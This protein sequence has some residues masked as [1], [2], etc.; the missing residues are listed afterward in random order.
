MGFEAGVSA[1]LVELKGAIEGVIE[2]L[3]GERPVSASELAARLGVSRAMGWRVWKLAG[4]E[5]VE[6]VAGRLPG[7]RA[8]GRFCD[9]ARA[10]GVGPALVDRAGRA[11]ARFR[12]LLAEQSWDSASANALLSRVGGGVDPGVEMR[13]RRELFRAQ[14]YTMGV[15]CLTQYNGFVAVPGPDVLRVELCFLTAYAGL[16]RSRGDQR[17]LINRR[18]VTN[19][20]GDT[21]YVRDGGLRYEALEATGGEFER[22]P[23]LIR[24]LCSDPTAP[25]RRRR[26]KDSLEDEL[27]P[28]EVGKTAATDVYFG[29]RLLGL[30]PDE[31]PTVVFYPRVRVPAE[32]LCEELILHRDA[33]DGSMPVSAVYT[34]VHDEPSF[35]NDDDR[36]RLP[37]RE[38]L[39]HVGSGADVVSGVA[40]SNAV[41]RHGEMMALLAERLGYAADEFQVYRLAMDYPPIPMTVWLEYP[42]KM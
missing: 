41:P 25:V 12:A 34:G 21:N 10:A 33:H 1:S 28:G 39:V 38:R 6:E 22:T 17:W 19:R 18:R 11:H 9:A 16:S 20:F 15:R 31:D 2:G 5:G 32:R 27:M 13:F 24:S 4:E 26:V 8:F 36:D 14:A 29:E 7:V 37:V 40:S 35:L 42:R 23:A 30:P 3:P